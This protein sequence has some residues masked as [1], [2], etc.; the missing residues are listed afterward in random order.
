LGLGGRWLLKCHRLEEATTNPTDPERQGLLA[1]LAREEDRLVRTG[2]AVLLALVLAEVAVVQPVVWFAPDLLA[3]VS[4]ADLKGFVDLLRA[5]ALL[6]SV[7]V[8]AVGLV[9]GSRLGSPAQPA[10]ETEGQREQRWLWQMLDTFSEGVVAFDHQGRVAFANQAATQLLQRRAL[11]DGTPMA[12]FADVPRLRTTVAAALLDRRLE[13]VELRTPGPPSRT[14]LARAAPCEDGAMLLMVDITDMRAAVEAREAFLSDAAHELRTPVAGISMGLEALSMGGLDDPTSAASL[15]GGVERQAARLQN[16]LE[17]LLSLA[18]LESGA[19]PLELQPVWVREAALAVVDLQG[20]EAA[21][22]IALEGPSDA[23]VRAD[24]SALDRMLT[25]LVTNALRY[26]DGEVVIRWGAAVH[27][28]RIAVEDRGPGLDDADKERVFER[29][30]RLD[31]GRATKT[32][33]TGLGLAIVKSLAERCGGRV[34]C[35]DN[36]PTGCRFVIEL[37]ST[38][39]PVPTAPE[40]APLEL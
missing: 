18:R 17:G 38:P 12:A 34:W 10:E 31:S 13:T 11:P 20:N 1:R 5:V 9:V 15:L 29:F 32:G 23:W 2:I 30:R 33:G 8:V 14:L 24:P 37:E 19:A 22:R 28:V 25:N 36:A 16:L 27:G 26:T 21:T 39:V 40:R 6:G 3:G 7:V 4:Q 35:E